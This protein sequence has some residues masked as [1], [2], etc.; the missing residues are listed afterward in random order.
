MPRRAKAHA[1]EDGRGL[2]HEANDMPLQWRLQDDR[3]FPIEGT[4]YPVRVEQRKPDYP[5]RRVPLYGPPDVPRSVEEIETER[6]LY[7]HLADAVYRSRGGEVRLVRN[8]RRLALDFANLYA[9]PV[10]CPLYPSYSGRGVSLSHFAREALLAWWVL[11]LRRRVKEGDEGDDTL[12]AAVQ[13]QWLEPA[14]GGLDVGWHLGWRLSPPAGFAPPAP[15]A[16][17]AAWDKFHGGGYAPPLPTAVRCLTPAKAKQ[18]VDNVRAYQREREQAEEDYV[19]TQGP[20]PFGWSNKRLPT[21]IGACV[22]SSL[23]NVKLAGVSPG[24]TPPLLPGFTFWTPRSRIWF[25]LWEDLGALTLRLCPQCGRLFIPPRRDKRFCAEKC[26]KLYDTR[27]CARTRSLQRLPRLPPHRMPPFRSQRP[28]SQEPLTA[29]Y[30]GPLARRP[31]EP[32]P[33]CLLR[34]RSML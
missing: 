26:R 19:K 33:S 6:R 3:L 28:H 13:V 30:S 8:W 18:E 31:P 24:Y 11:E 23:M 17:A 7:L 34:L 16:N 21:Y 9:P 22:L 4:R 27:L 25:G 14:S 20:V 1:D 2:Y 29:A 32:F 12:I 10:A 15:S 5:A